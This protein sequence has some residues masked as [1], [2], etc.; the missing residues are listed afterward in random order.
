M[1][2][3]V[4]LQDILLLTQGELDQVPEHDELRDA[5]A[6][7]GGRIEWFSSAREY[8]SKLFDLGVTP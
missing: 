4:R 6:R 5:V 1:A 3:D 8:F 2:R 7:Y